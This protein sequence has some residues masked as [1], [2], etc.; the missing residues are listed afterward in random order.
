MTSKYI[1]LLTLF[2]ALQIGFVQ[3]QTTFK[4]PIIAGMNPD[5]SICRVGDDFYLV[6]STF[7][8]FPGVPIYHSKDLINWRIIGHALSTPVNCPLMDANSSGGNYA[9]AI[10]HHNGT[11]YV[12]CTNYGGQG[13]EGAFY[14][15]ATNPEGPWSDPVWVGNWNVDPSIMFANDS[16]YWVSPDNKGSFMV[17]T[18]DPESK[19]FIKPLQLIASGLGGSSP[20]GPHMYKIN[21]YYYLMSAE[22]GTGYEHREVIQ[23][24]KSP[25]GPFEASPYNPVISNMNNLESPFHAIGH[26]DLVQLK[27]GSWWLV[28]LGFRP[29]GGN[30][31]H[32][33]RETFLA[34]VIWTQD[35][36]PIAVFHKI[37]IYK[38]R[39]IMNH[40]ILAAGILFLSIFG[41]NAQGLYVGVN[42]HP[43]D[44]KNIVKI[45]TD[46]QLMKVA[47]FN[48][49]RLGHLAWDSY[50]PADGQFDFEW[51]DEVMDL[52]AEAD[53]KVILDIAIRP[54]PIWLH[55]KY[56]SIKV[57]DDRGNRLYPNHRYMDDVG[58]PYFQK[59]AVRFTDVMSKRYANHSALLAFGIDNESGDGQISYSET[60]RLRFVEWLKIKY[61]T[62]NNL[63]KSWATHRWSRRIN[64]FDEVG[65]PTA[66]HK[67]GAPEKILDFRRFV[68][69]EV[70]QSVFKVLDVVNKN[71]PNAY[72]NTNAWFYSGMKYFDYA[73]IAYSGK[74]THGGCG[75]YYGSS[76]TTNW[77]VMNAAFGISRIHYESPNPFWCN[78]F[79]TMTATPNSIRKAAYA[80]LMYGNQMIGGWTWQSM[81]AGE[82]QYLQGLVDWDGVTNRKYDEYMQIA[83]EFKRIEKF[84][85]Y[86]LQAEV[87]LAF[88][89]PSQIASTSF[90]EQHENQVQACWDMFY[91]RNMDSRV[92]E[93]SRS[94][95]NYK[96]LFVPGVTVMDELTASKI[97][98]Y[99]YNGGT[100]IMTSNSAF[101]DTTG[102]VFASTRPGI[103]SDV[104]G[105]R[106]GSYEE[107]E[108]MNEISRKSYQG[109]KLEFTY[110]GKTIDT[111]STRF[112]IVEPKG[113]QVIGSLT[114]LDKD[115]PI[116][117]M[118]KY[119]KGQAIYVGL[120]AKGEVLGPIVDQLIK[121][122]DMKKGPEVPSGVMARQIDEKHFLYL[123]VS[124]QPKEIKMNVKSRSILFDKD[125]TGNFTINPYEPEFIEIK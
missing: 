28:C 119:G 70:N 6:T 87:G 71:A 122:L 13:S 53:I 94:S 114:S 101:V 11:F 31:H 52:M 18:Y 83:T 90:P 74:M 41:V 124:G 33:G 67:N 110:K 85:P 22:G 21:D 38:I 57:V 113:A 64:N 27:D 66:G 59:Y 25:Y 116:M 40:L 45:K 48:V 5:P 47:G 84:F 107:T 42:Y 120:P 91:Y 4:N 2:I 23:R 8:Y 82:E 79:T 51:F 81:W 60:V 121:E 26:A 111:E 95:L 1:V 44:D 16:M 63:N 43:H 98:E 76:L 102:Q 58:D 39:I 92:V 35:G 75:F 96:L 49:V 93:I 69:D 37:E 99:V 112:D 100:V 123:N 73:P 80:S 117:T 24:S 14:V 20:E 61:G 77:G 19:Q 12:S 125:Y 103:L 104:F 65:L 46:I 9:P 56:P 62:L 88:S 3:G 17:G 55:Q 36:W 68:S 86:N 34:P 78:E 54:A 50:E 32:L 15:T 109:I 106:V 10:R 115:Y 7:E 97:R 89:F 29:K 108:A 72:T 30:H 118:N 105:I